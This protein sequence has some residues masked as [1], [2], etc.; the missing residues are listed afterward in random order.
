MKKQEPRNRNLQ[1]VTL[2]Q[3]HLN[4]GQLSYRRMCNNLQIFERLHGALQTLYLLRKGRK[5]KFLKT[6]YSRVWLFIL[7]LFSKRWLTLYNLRIKDYKYIVPVA[8]HVPLL[9]KKTGR[10]EKLLGFARSHSIVIRGSV[11][12]LCAITPHPSC[13][14][15]F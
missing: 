15:H 4:T 7:S 2:R 11:S 5:M 14:S 8:S 6:F 9:S 1:L 3:N 13:F 10:F 12:L